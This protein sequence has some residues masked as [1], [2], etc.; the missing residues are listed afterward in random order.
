MEKKLRTL[1]Y[2][3][4]SLGALAAIL[5]VTPMPYAVMFAVLTGFFGLLCSSIYVFI[6]TRNELNVK[7]F[8]PGILGMI[9]SSIPIL[10]MLA[11]IILS[12]INR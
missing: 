1:G 4:V 7:R 12:K 6:D 9:L 10:F 2:I 5:C 3:S 8:T 11:I